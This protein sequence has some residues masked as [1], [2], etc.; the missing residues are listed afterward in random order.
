[1]VI[2]NMRH[3][4][5][6]FLNMAK[7]VAS[8]SK[9]PSTQ[10]GAVITDTNH[11]LI[12]VGFN[13]FARGVDDMPE[14]LQDRDIKL[15]LMVH[16]EENALLFARQSLEGCTMYT[17]PMMMCS[18]CMSKAIQAGI[19]RHVTLR[20]DNA[21][22]NESFKLSTQIANEAGIYLSLYG[23]LHDTK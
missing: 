22:W 19:R 15:K 11:R 14:R 18:S 7:L 23:E 9:D 4:D 12:S 8:W 5:M 10:C 6:R 3:W 16:A 2:L 17:W 21:R 13:G 1:M 20:N